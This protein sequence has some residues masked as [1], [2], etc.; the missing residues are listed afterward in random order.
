MSWRRQHRSRGLP[1]SLPAGSTTACRFLEVSLA[2]H[3][4]LLGPSCPVRGLNQGQLH[5]TVEADQSSAASSSLSQ[6]VSPTLLARADD[7]LS[8][9]GGTPKH[10][11]G[12]C[13]PSLSLFRCSGF[14]SDRMRWQPGFSSRSPNSSS[15]LC[16]RGKLPQ[17]AGRHCCYATVAILFF[18][19]G[20]EGLTQTFR[21][22]A[23]CWIAKQL[24]EAVSAETP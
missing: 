16:R 13:G 14:T 3:F 18:F 5:P 19:R 10:I 9:T 21:R 22:L 2:A 17:P 8:A 7:V 12:P 1:S 11:P 23:T 24:L 15:V 4:P 6:R 20:F